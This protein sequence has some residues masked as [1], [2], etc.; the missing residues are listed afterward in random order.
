MRVL[1]VLLVWIG[2]VW[3]QSGV[4]LVQVDVEPIGSRTS[5]ESLG[6]RGGNKQS[7]YYQRFR[8]MIDSSAPTQIKRV[9]EGLELVILDRSGQ[10]YLAL[11]RSPIASKDNR[12]VVVRYDREGRESDRVELTPFVTA[13]YPLEVQDIRLDGEVLYFNASSPTYASKTKG[14]SSALY[15]YDLRKHTLLWRSNYLRSNNI[16]LVSECCLITGYGFTRE[17][18]YLYLID[19]TTG[20]V[21][22]HTKL[23]TAHSY[24]EIQGNRLYVMTYNRLYTFEL[25]S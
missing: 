25:S 16:F 23:D 1:V 24:L 2:V 7:N 12:F 17:P 21:R 13:R 18:D 14:K 8:R 4:R 20:K 5:Y 11:Y 10:G 22:D 3:G 19:K 9:L 6:L 15:A